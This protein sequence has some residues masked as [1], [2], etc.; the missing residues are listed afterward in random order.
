MAIFD[1]ENASAVIAYLDCEDDL[2]LGSLVSISFCNV[3][4]AA[5]RTSAQISMIAM[6]LILVPA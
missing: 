1:E 5:S 4:A 2:K 3:H 6:V